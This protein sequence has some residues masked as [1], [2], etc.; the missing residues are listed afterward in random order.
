LKIYFLVLV[1]VCAVLLAAQTDENLANAA[2]EADTI[3]A[4]ITIPPDMHLAKQEDF[5]YVEADSVAGLKLGDTIWIGD[6]HKDEL[7]IINYEKEVILKRPL[8]MADDL[9]ANGFKIKVYVGYQICFDAFCKP[10]EEL[11]F[12]LEYSPINIK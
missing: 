10:P 7:G 6:P 2:I 9:K 5:V 4:T 8:F 11:E 3:V 1:L 12:D